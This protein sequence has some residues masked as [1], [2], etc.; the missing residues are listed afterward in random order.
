[1]SCSK[2]VS[3]LGRANSTKVSKII[4][5]PGRYR[6]TVASAKSKEERSQL[7]GCAMVE[8]EPVEL[9][10]HTKSS[11]KAH[12]NQVN[13]DF[14]NTQEAYKSKRNIELLRSLLVFRLCAIDIL[15]DKNKEVSSKVQCLCGC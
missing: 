2:L 13:I 4:V 1:M 8:A 10:S 15:V 5:A 6:S 3:A 7:D 9:I 14:D 11:P 12:K